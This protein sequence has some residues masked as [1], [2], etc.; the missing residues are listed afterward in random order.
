MKGF[1]L[2]ENGDI[3]ITDGQI[4][5]ISGAELETQTIKTI[6]STNKGESPFNAGEGID[7]K[8]ILSKGVTEDMIKTQIQS[9]IFQ[10]NPE[11]VIDEF[12]Y[13]VKDR[14]AVI[15]FT[16]RKPNGSAISA[17]VDIS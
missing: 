2:T 8:Q 3:S 14:H 12:E 16:A 7:H 9:G 17:S 11:R 13:A 10:V 15:D 6:L 4:D 5:M 1:K